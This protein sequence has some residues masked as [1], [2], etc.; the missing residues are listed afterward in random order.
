VKNA[1]ILLMLAA[2]LASQAR[3]AEPPK[4]SSPEGRFE[5]CL[6]PRRCGPGT[7]K[8]ETKQPQAPKKETAVKPVPP[9]SFSADPLT[10]AILNEQL[11]GDGIVSAVR[12]KEDHILYR[13]KSAVGLP[14]S[15]VP[16]DKKEAK[17]PQDADWAKIDS[18]GKAAQQANSMGSEREALSGSVAE[19]TKEGTDRMW[20]EK[21]KPRT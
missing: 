3:A 17:D 10:R 8:P 15:A 5:F 20:G 4:G 14:K 21:E 18:E 2:A 19:S 13:G 7:N 1:A 6:W 11:S 12:L 16:S 9:L